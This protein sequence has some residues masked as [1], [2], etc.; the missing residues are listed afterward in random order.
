MSEQ[1]TSKSPDKNTSKPLQGFN[2]DGPR[3]Y[4]IVLHRISMFSLR[5]ERPLAV[6]IACTSIIILVLVIQMLFWILL[7]FSLVPATVVI[8]F[9]TTLVWRLPGSRERGMKDVL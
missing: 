2:F 6:M 3:I 7:G 5:Y 8:F 9:L 4:R 1:S